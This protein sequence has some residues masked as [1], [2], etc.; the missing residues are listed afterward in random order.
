MWYGLV[1]VNINMQK[2]Y[3]NMNPLCEWMMQMH[4]FV[5]YTHTEAHATLSR[6]AFSLHEHIHEHFTISFE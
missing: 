3:L 1:P 4:G 2:Y 6:G 5:Y